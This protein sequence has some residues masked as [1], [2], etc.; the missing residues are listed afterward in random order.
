MAQSDDS[1]V[2]N[3]NKQNN[4]VCDTLGV[5]CFVEDESMVSRPVTNTMSTPSI[6]EYNESIRNFMQ[7]PQL[8][9]SILYSVSQP[10]GT[11]LLSLPLGPLLNS[12]SLWTNKID[13]YGLVR[14]TAVV[15]VEVN[16]MKFHSG[17]L[18]AHYI[19]NATSVQ[20]VEKRFNANLVQKM[21]HPGILFDVA[22]TMA[23]VKVPYISPDSYYKVEP[24]SDLYTPDWGTFYLDV[25][26]PLRV[27]TGDDDLGIQV[28]VY[29]ED[30]EFS[31][32]MVAQ[33]DDKIVRKKR[34]EDIAAGE[35][36]SSTLMNISTN[37][38]KL[39][40]IPMIGQYMSPLSWVVRATSLVASAFG[41]SKI[42][43]NVSHTVMVQQPNRY[44]GV[45]EGSD[46]AIPLGVNYDNKLKL[47][48]S[49][50]LTGEDEMTYSYLLQKIPN[51]VSTFQWSTSGFAGQ[52]LLNRNI[53]PSELCVLSSVSGTTTTTTYA[54]G[55]PIFYLG[56]VHALY[57]GSIVLH[58]KIAKT[59][60]HSGSLSITFTPTDTFG[61]APSLSDGRALR[62]I[63]D[64][65]DQSEITM[66]LP[67][68]NPKNYLEVNN[69]VSGV[70]FQQ[71]LGFLNIRVLNTLVTSG[72]ASPVVDIIE[73]YT[74]GDDFEYA[75][76]CSP[77]YQ[78]GYSLPFYAQSDDTLVMRKGIADT[79]I[80]SRRLDHAELSTGESIL[81]IK[82][83][84]NR[85]SF[86]IWSAAVPTA[87][88]LEICPWY[89]GMV[90]TNAVTGALTRGICISD[91]MSYFSPMYL[92]MRGG[93]RVYQVLNDSTGAV[94]PTF[95]ALQVA[96]K[97]SP[98]PY[99]STSL[100]YAGGKN[101]V[102]TLGS[103]TRQLTLNSIAP[104]GFTDLTPYYKVPYMSRTP[105][106]IINPDITGNGMIASN[107]M[108]TSSLVLSTYAATHS[109]SAGYGRAAA[110][111]FQLSMFL[112]CPSL[113]ISS[114]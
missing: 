27:G 55:G 112:A 41:Y 87:K 72:A 20:D 63:L 36:L 52:T 12:V 96:K 2:S 83:F 6:E 53:S 15:R 74:A 104:S 33:S 24:V 38:S 71:N 82:Q 18:L 85:V 31:A 21:Q 70:T 77:Q 32:P 40:S 76:P 28:Y 101:F 93:I 102:T 65:R 97:V 91:A 86:G 47:T 92:Y 108:P 90:S 34:N 66:V 95:A 81:S 56:N 49:F 30:L 67:Y 3:S 13:G 37:V 89:V 105:V 11:N 1:Y 69:K 50:S 78:S 43:A 39:S 61:I 25:F 57:R 29:W 51:Y 84:L 113:V 5:T 111:D 22:Q 59:N 35:K 44:L 14:G 106:A 45:S 46:T 79:R 60:F 48:N 107:F 100:E 16:A 54:T 110:D 94:Q 103:T 42:E 10:A 109:S 7:R 23:T 19:P 9:S 88:S 8:I 114:A 98:V 26:T 62:Q 73:Y 17:T 4:V 99:L 64:I 80:Q 68:M 58:L 75:M